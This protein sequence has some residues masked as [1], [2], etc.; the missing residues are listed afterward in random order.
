MTESAPLASELTTAGALREV[1]EQM[2]VLA[3]L[4]RASYRDGALSVDPALRPFGLK[5]LRI[6]SRSGPTHASAVAD[7]LYV[8]RSV[9]SREARQL[10]RLGLIEMQPDPEDGRAR[11]LALTP[12]AERKLAVTEKLPIFTRLATWAPED[13]HL[14][15]TMLERLNNPSA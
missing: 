2:S 10:E 5:V 6:L 11:Y 12:E 8:D 14:F 1:E 9:I 3:G 15:A 4:I 7:M 13:I